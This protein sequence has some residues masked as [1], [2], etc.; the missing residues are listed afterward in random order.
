MEE[1]IGFAQKQNDREREKAYLDTCNKD[2]LPSTSCFLTRTLSNLINHMNF[3][4]NGW[5]MHYTDPWKQ[6]CKAALLLE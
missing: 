3:L 5:T 2:F 6:V 1:T 4:I